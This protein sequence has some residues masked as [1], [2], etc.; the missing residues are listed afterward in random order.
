MLRHFML[1][2]LVCFN[3]NFAAKIKL[4]TEI[5]F[6]DKEVITSLAPGKKIIA[7]IV[8][9]VTLTGGEN[10]I[11][12]HIEQQS[13]RDPLFYMRMLAYL[14]GLYL[15][16]K[17]PVYPIALLTYATPD[18]TGEEETGIFEMETAGEIVLKFQYKVVAV[19][20]LHWQEY[21]NRNNPA[22]AALMGAM[23][24]KEDERVIAKLAAIEQLVEC[25]LTPEESRIIGLCLDLSLIHI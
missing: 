4:D 7:D 19:H 22:A 18:K 24:V 12:V 2:F 16:Y 17:I 3:P 1:P 9:I 10:C 20:N 8:A 14:I 15:K 13:I 5:K 6:L 21:A 23:N 25:K 11:I